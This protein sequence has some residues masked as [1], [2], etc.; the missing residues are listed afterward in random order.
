MSI[1]YIQGE[2]TPTLLPIIMTKVK[3]EESR[4]SDPTTLKVV[5]SGSPL[6]FFYCMACCSRRKRG[7][8]CE[9][10]TLVFFFGVLAA[11]GGRWG[12]EECDAHPCVLFRSACCRGGR[13]FKSQGRLLPTFPYFEMV[14]PHISPLKQWDHT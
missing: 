9:M 3:D 12:G 13:M 4:Q 14:D 10:P 8:G 7:G 5:M 2:I 11:A 1:F 6:C